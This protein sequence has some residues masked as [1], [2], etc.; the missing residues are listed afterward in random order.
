M[1][2]AGNNDSIMPALLSEKAIDAMDSGK[3]PYRDIIS[4]DMLKK[5]CE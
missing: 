4:T 3:E 1:Q 2:K 5:I